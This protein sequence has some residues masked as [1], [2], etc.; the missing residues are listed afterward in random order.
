MIIKKTIA[1]FGPGTITLFTETE[2][3]FSIRYCD[4]CAQEWCGKQQCHS[5][6]YGYREKKFENFK[7]QYP[8]F[9]I[10]MWSPF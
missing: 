7:W 3:N 2:W 10:G 6:S 5:N 9:C 1:T 8:A 4:V